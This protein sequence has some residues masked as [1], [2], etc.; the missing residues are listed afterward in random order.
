MAVVA[1]DTQFMFFF[2]IPIKAKWLALI[3][4]GLN[5]ISLVN[6]FPMSATYGWCSLV[7]FGFSLVNFLMFFGRTL[8][9]TVLN[10]IRVVRTRRS[11]RTGR[12]W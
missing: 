12:G 3:N 9:E 5:V 10:Q 2:L 11:W 1:P 4:V 8:L 6:A 7:V